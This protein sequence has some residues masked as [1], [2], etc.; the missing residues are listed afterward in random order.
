MDSKQFL[1]FVERQK[2]TFAKT[3]AAFAPHEYIVRNQIDG[4]DE[5]FVEAVVHI[6]EAGMRMFYYKN[7]RKYLFIDGH[8]YW[9]MGNALEDTT[10]IN[11]CIP[12]DYDIVFLKKGT[13][14]K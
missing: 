13:Q 6:R 5:E 9:T 12:D 1:E 14:K 4:T 3:Y 7:E 8:F 11:R 2:W 10:I